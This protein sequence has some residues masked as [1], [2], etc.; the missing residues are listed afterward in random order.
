MKLIR[1]HNI[2]RHA[3]GID[4]SARLPETRMPVLE[5]PDTKT[6]SIIRIGIRGEWH[7]TLDLV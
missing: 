1:Q 4:V 3:A 5:K 7:E 6:A 2:N